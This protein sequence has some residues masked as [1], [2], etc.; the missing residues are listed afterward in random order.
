[1]NFIDAS[2]VFL[3]TTNQILTAG[4]AITAVALFLYS[5][6]FNLRE[7][8]PRTFALILLSVVIVFS[9]E[10]F[11]STFNEPND[12]VD[13]WLRMEWVGIILLPATYLHFSAALLMTT[14]HPANGVNRFLVTFNYFVALVFL[15]TLPFPSV[16]GKVVIEDQNLHYFNLTQVTLAFTIYY[17]ATMAVTWFRFVHAYMRTLT[18]TSRRRMGYLIVGAFAPALGSFPY[19]LYGFNLIAGHQ[20]LFWLAAVIT[21]ALVGVLLVLM[22]YAVAFFGVT[23]PDRVV[24]RRLFK[25]L[26]RGPVTASITLG[27]VTVVRRAGEQFGYP[28][29]AIV[30]IVMVANILIFEYLIGLI[31]PY[32]EKRFFYGRDQKDLEIVNNLET[33]LLTQQDLRQIL[34]MILAAVCDRIRAPGAYIATLDGERLELMVTIGSHHF[35]QSEAA[36]E[37]QKMFSEDDSNTSFFRWGDDYLFPLIDGIADQEKQLY[38]IMGVS[39]I[40]ETPLDTEQE[41]A[42]LLLTHRAAIVLHDRTVQQ[43]VFQSLQNLTPEV[44]LIQR[45][46]AAG[47]YDERNVL[48]NEPLLP[49]DDIVQ[50]VKEALTHYWGGP[51]LTESPLRELLIVQETSQAFDGNLTNALRVILKEAIERIKP[52]GE[53]RFTGEWILYNILEMKF[54]EGKKVREIALRLAM[55]EA[56]LYRKQRVAIEAVA[57]EILSMEAQAQSEGKN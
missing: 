4:I 45:L 14:G 35:E 47:R 26:M 3:R 36:L 39:A 27:L 23:W 22:A 49:P 11:G 30:P 34:E 33:R 28:Y 31:G 46:R 40:A 55:S 48:L 57:K 7:R 20:V 8:V 9:A 29:P 42:I 15:A 21:N 54:L 5:L 25:W 53:R 32:I 38:G 6:Q 10:A 52:E 43:K 56:D 37:V 19:L 18:P 12:V 24:K 51:K 44:E 50:W 13:F 2:V 16:F 41:R 17:L 1:M